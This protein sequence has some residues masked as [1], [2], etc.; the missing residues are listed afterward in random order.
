MRWARACEAAARL[1]RRSSIHFT[2]RPSWRAIAATATSSGKTWLLRPKP[3]PTSGTRILTRVEGRSSTA[4]RAVW[5]T[6]GVW[7]DAHTVSVSPSQSARTPRGS[8]GD[9]ARGPRGWREPITLEPRLERPGERPQV[10]GGEDAQ[11]AV[12]AARRARVHP[13]D[14]RVG[15]RAPHEGE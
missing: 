3:P 6:E 1:S 7:V 12:E 4:A 2:G 10:V 9:G 5:R 15:V 11:D 8:S 14:R 13:A